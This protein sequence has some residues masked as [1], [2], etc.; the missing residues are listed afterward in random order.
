MRLL[1]V[2]IGGAFACG[3]FAHASASGIAAPMADRRPAAIATGKLLFRNN[4]AICHKASGVGGIHFGK[5]ASAN[6]QSPHL[7]MVYHNK[8]SL[9]ARAIIDAEDQHDR[10]LNHVMP[11]WRGRLTGMQVQDIIAYLRTLHA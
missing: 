9:I 4:C 2:V 10:P 8:D 3:L 6:L 5:V 7:E 1:L 11:A